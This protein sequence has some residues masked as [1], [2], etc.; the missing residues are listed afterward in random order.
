M[1]GNTRLVVFTAISAALYASIL[2][3]FKVLPIIPGVTE[4]RPANAVPVVCSLLFGPAAAWGSAIGNLIGDLFAGIG[5][6]DLF[7]FFGNLLYGLVPYRAWDALT[8]RDPVPETVGDWLRLVAVILIAAAACALVIGWGLNFLGFVPFPVLGTV[9]FFNNFVVAAVLA[10]LLLR[11]L[12]PR[13]RAARLTYRDL[14]GPRGGW[15]RSVRIVILGAGA[16]AILGG[17]VAGHLIY[18]RSW[19]PPWIAPVVG[20]SANRSLEVGLGVAPFVAAAFACFLS[21]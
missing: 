6:G 7:G 16:A 9:V 21:L 20:V 15:P 2:I 8:D 19:A 18:A 17:H 4:F 13:V 5:P 12:H 10:P 14:A 3:P 11:V 1:W